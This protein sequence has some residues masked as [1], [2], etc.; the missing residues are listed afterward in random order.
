MDAEVTRIDSILRSG[1][2]PPLRYAFKHFS[3]QQDLHLL[4]LRVERSQIGPHR[5]IFRGHDKFY[6]RHST[7]KYPL[8]TQELRESFLRSDT[9]EERVRRFRAERVAELLANNTPIAFRPGPKFVLHLIPARAL[10]SGEDIDIGPVTEHHVHLPPIAAGGWDDRFTF[11]GYM[12]YSA[13]GTGSESYVHLYRSGIIEAVAARI[14]RKHDGKVVLPAVGY[15]KRIINSLSAYIQVLKALNVEVPIVG[16]LSFLGVRGCSL[17]LGDEI[18]LHSDHPY[19]LDRETLE[20]PELLIESLDEAPVT[21]LRPAFD[22]VWNAFG[23]ER[24]FNYD[25]QENWRGSQ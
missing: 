1:I 25:D 5:V 8:N 24:S 20:L 16:Y 9:I 7:G 14:A 15:E 22:L 19:P 12:T 6:Q 3:L 18:S 21:I 11:E 4:V 10:E 13:R 2:E 23:Y 17:L